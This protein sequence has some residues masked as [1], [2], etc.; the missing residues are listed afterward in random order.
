MIL[1][2]FLLDKFND[3]TLPQIDGGT[4]GNLPPSGRFGKA[5]V[6][7]DEPRRTKTLSQ[8]GRSAA[9]TRACAQ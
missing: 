6:L 1:S 3:G 5:M 7:P 4:N 2:Q 9:R 8:T